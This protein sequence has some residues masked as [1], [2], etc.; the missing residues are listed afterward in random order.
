LRL[1]RSGGR[2]GEAIAHHVAAALL[3]H[4]IGDSYTTATALRTLASRLAEAPD[5]AP[6][7]TL[8]ELAAAVEQVEGVRYT[9]LITAI[10]RGN[11]HLADRALADLIHTAPPPDP[12]LEQHLS[13]WDPLLAAL[14]AAINGDAPVTQL[15]TQALDRYA[16]HQDWAELVDRLRRI[17]A[18]ERD[19]AQ[20]LAGLDEID[21]AITR[22]AL[23][24]IAGRI[25]L[26]ISDDQPDT[27]PPSA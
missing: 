4:L 20:L 21:T 16:D 2:P 8:A 11:I 17:Q 12:G 13:H 26:T 3:G 19:P 9:A 15:L 10:T 14:V 22:R 1:H 7:A 5:L 18:G 6:P 27:E 25:Q 23:D 24:A